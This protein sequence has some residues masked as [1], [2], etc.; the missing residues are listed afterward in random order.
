MRRSPQ[1]Y[2]PSFMEIG[3]PVPEKKILERL[4]HIWA[5]RPSWSCD[6]H[7]INNFYF[8]VPKSLHTQYLQTF[9]T[10]ISCLHLPTFRPLAAIVFEKSTVF[11]FSIEKTKFSN[12]TCRKIGQGQPSVTIIQTFVELGSPMLHAKFQDHRISDSEEQDF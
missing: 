9:I 4:Y 1:C 8:H 7:H 5:L 3:P 10:S 11:N 2:I 6:Q 12:L